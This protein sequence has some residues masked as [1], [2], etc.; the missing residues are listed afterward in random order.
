MGGILSGVLVGAEPRLDA[1]SP[2]AGGVGLTDISVRARQI[3]VPEA[4]IMPM[5]GQLIVGCIPTDADQNPISVDNEDAPNCLQKEGPFRGGEFG[6]HLWSMIM[7][8]ILC[9]SLHPSLMFVGDRI[10]IKIH[11]AEKAK[12]AF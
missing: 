5:L 2:N 8:E 7:H 9:T 4:V 11:V 3:G 10:R 1:V 12:R 6:W